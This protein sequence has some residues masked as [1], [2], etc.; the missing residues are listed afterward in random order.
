MTLAKGKPF[1]P[2]W[3]GRGEILLVDKP[4]EWTSFDVVKKVRSLFRIR[5]IGHAGTLD[6]KATGLLILCTG[7]RTK[8]VT[9]FMELEK[10]YSGTMELGISTA[11]FDM[12]TPILARRSIDGVSEELLRSVMARFTG[13]QL[14]VP[15]MYSAAKFGGKPLYKFA[16]RGRTVERATKEI[17]VDL[18]DLVAFDPPRAQFAVQCSKGTYIRSLVHDVGRELG[19][20]AVLTALR[21]TRI[22]S[23]DVR[24]AWTVDELITLKERPAAA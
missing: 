22:G 2:D 5:K 6:P 24:D 14:Q 17:S 8:S 16:R 7:P 3:N 21:R 1:K 20:G 15:P 10:V 19:C 11:S 4:E 23:Y 13:K 12:E 18:F 9:R